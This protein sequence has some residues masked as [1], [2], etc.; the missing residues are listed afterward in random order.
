MPE[1]LKILNTALNDVR[2]RVK[3]ITSVMPL[4]YVIN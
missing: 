1:G 2:V 3:F 4:T